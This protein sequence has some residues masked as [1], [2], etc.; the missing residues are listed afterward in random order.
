MKV[1]IVSSELSPIAKEGGLGDAV[2]GLAPALDALGCEVKVAIPGYGHVLENCPGAELITENVRVS[3]GYFNMTAGLRKV[4]PAPGVEAYMVCNESL[5][6]RHGVYGD[7]AGLFMDNHKRYIFFSKSIPALCSATRYIP[8]VI[9]AN[10]WQ[11]G[12]IPALMDQGHMPQTASVFVIHNIGYLGYVPPED[13]S[14][15]GLSNTYLTYEGMEFYGQLSLLKAGIAYANKLVTVSPTYSRE[16]QTT[17][18]GAGLDGLMRKR[19]QDLAGI[20]NGVDFQVWS[21]ETDKHIPCNYSKTDMAGKGECKKAL[22]NEMGMDPQ[23][24]KAPVAGMVT[25]LFSQKGIELVI[26]ALPEIVESGM[27]FILLGNGEE[28]YARDLRR[29]ARAYPGRFRFEEAFN[30]PLAHRIIAG[31]DMLCVPSLYEPCGLT[32]MYALQYGTIPVARATGGL[33]DTVRDIKAFAGKGNGF[34]FDAFSPG[35]FANAM[36]RAGRYYKNRKAW[37]ALTAKAMASAG[38]FTW[39][40]AAEQYYSIF[41]RA[42]RARRL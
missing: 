29:L 25:R 30:E 22:L 38:V 20:L 35:A 34:T 4:E 9:L 31:T 11:T 7:N 40:M 2:A 39:D 18:Q 36:D 1:L 41:E 42:V 27:G 5:F 12:L 28:S 8:D 10:D 23:L 6:G 32:Q 26:G 37:S 21:P 19:S 13:A 15:L 17:E 14:M 3:M 24:M 33:A 16:I